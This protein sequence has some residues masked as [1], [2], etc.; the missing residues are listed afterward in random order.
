MQMQVKTR[1]A[2]PEP[3]SIILM[4]AGLV[5]LLAFRRTL[6]S[7]WLSSTNG[8]GYAQR[9][10]YSFCQAC[11][12]DAFRVQDLKR[13]TLSLDDPEARRAVNRSSSND[14]AT[15]IFQLQRAQRC[16]ISLFALRTPKLCKIA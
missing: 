10:N 1:A 2:V 5:V 16:K 14:A 8:R 13:A 9:Y 4:L 6:P 7:R 15:R 3:A 11:R 12:L